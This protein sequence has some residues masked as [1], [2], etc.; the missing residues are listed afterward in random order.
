MTS[1]KR[2]ESPKPVAPAEA[3]AADAGKDKVEAKVKFVPPP[4]PEGLQRSVLNLYGVLAASVL[5]WAIIGQSMMHPV[6]EGKFEKKDGKVIDINDFDASDLGPYPKCHPHHEEHK[7]AGENGTVT[8]VKNSDAA[9]GGPF[10]VGHPENPDWVKKADG[11]MKAD[12]KENRFKWKGLQVNFH[13]LVLATV[14]V[15]LGSKHGLWI[16]TEPAETREAGPPVLQSEDAYWFPVL[17]SGMLL[18]LFL[19]LKYLGTYWIKTLITCWIVMICTV[20]I[21]KNTDAVVAVYKKARAKPLFRIPYFDEEVTLL[22]IAGSGVGACMA[23]CYIY[24][25]NW[26]VNNVFGLSFCLLGI[27]MIGISS[28]KVGVIMFIGLFFYDVF[29]VFGSKSVFGS[30]VMV[31]VATG[32]EAPIKLLF[33]RDL[34]GCGTLRNSMLGLGDIVVPGIF[35]AFLAKWDAVKMGEKASTSFVYLNTVMVAYFLSLVTTVSIMLFFNAAQPALLYIVPYVLIATFGVAASRGEL[36]ELWKFE[37][38]DE[39]AEAEEAKKDEKK[40]D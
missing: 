35:I 37:I 25:Q 36:K 11:L 12:N 19:V 3:D 24:S 23:A 28:I 27:R 1:R 29:W 17:G 39:S 33:P 40:E 16:F 20:G 2:D 7:V 8:W 10:P 26:I 32:V 18:G 34:S 38:P 4:R 31:S 14:T 15:F 9:K 22:E 5:V 21:G 30:N 6:P 13:L